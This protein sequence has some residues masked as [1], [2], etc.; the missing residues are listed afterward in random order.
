M[1]VITWVMV[2]LVIA[3]A[4][5]LVVRPAQGC[6]RA[7]PATHTQPAVKPAASPTVHRSSF[8]IAA[9]MGWL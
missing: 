8:V 2:V 5:F 4:A 6:S 3:G 9:R 7:H 1:K